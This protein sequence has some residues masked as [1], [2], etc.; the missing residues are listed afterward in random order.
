MIVGIPK[1]SWVEERR[2]AL[3]PAGVY[4]LVKAGHTVIVQAE[5][6]LMSGFPDQ[7][8]AEA[9][10]RIAF[11]PEEVYARADLLVKVLP[12]TAEE[13]TW[14]PERRFLYSMV[15]LGTASSKVCEML[16]ERKATAVGFELIEDSE[17]NLPVLTAMSEIAGMLL[18]QIA[19]RFLETTHGGRGVL[20]GGVAGIPASHV[21]IIGAGMVGSTAAR[22]FA[23]SGANVTVM[24]E[25]LKRLRALEMLLSKMVNT[26]LATPYNIERYVASA[27]VV[28]GAVLIRGRKPP[29]VVTESMVR[30]MRP[31][32]V[33]L[34]LSIDQGGCVQTSRP[35]TLSEPVFKK[36]GVTHYCVPNV[37]SAVARTASHALNNVLLSFV[38]EVAENGI[39]AFRSDTALRRGVYLYLGQCTHEGLAGLLGL[40]YASIETLIEKQ[41]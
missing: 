40:E 31:G 14:I 29:H 13:S 1:E 15:H 22:I 8:F 27:D 30:K 38:E 9:G 24:D 12:P 3:S 2:V 17:Q 28:V 19:G 36:Y 25:D 35:T 26:A 16:R 39:S 37:P 5:A 33:I 20:L 11:S 34:D 41:E 4:A 21:V 10:G 18:P 23:G 32:S 7:A 6:G